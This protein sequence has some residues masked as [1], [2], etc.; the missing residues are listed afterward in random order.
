MIDNSCLLFLSNTW[1]RCF[2]F[3]S[4]SNFLCLPGTDS[5]INRGWTGMFNL[6]II[7][8]SNN[9]GEVFRWCW[10]FYQNRWQIKRIPDFLITIRK[11]WKP[12]NFLFP[13]YAPLHVQLCNQVMVCYTVDLNLIK[14]PVSSDIVCWFYVLNKLCWWLQVPLL[15]LHFLWMIDKVNI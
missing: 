10:L 4:A 5:Y 12:V 1:F 9:L 14:A 6:T 8:S 3:I 13:F 15:K 7:N 2:F 11:Y